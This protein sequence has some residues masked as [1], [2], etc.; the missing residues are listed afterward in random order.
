MTALTELKKSEKRL[1]VDEGIVT[2]RQLMEKR[3]ALRKLGIPPERIGAIAAEM[4]A[5][6]EPA[7]VS[8]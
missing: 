6:R 3:D 5:V 4:E 8:G 7:S 2:T 1:L